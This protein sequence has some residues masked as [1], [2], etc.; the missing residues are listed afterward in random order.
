MLDNSE[1]DGQT[2]GRGVFSRLKRVRRDYASVV[3]PGAIAALFT[4]LF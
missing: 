1:P 2:F 4:P 3:Y